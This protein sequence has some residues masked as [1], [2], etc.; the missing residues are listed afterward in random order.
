[1][2]CVLFVGHF[3][4][5]GSNV[6]ETNLIAQLKKQTDDLEIITI[7]KGYTELES[8]FLDIPVHAVKA[9]KKPV[10]DE[11]IRFFYM[12]KL[13]RKW[14]KKT[15]QN[16]A[17][18][19]LL[20]ASLEITLAVLIA[21]KLFKIKAASLIID[22]ALGNFKPDTLWNKYIYWCY[23]C[24]EKLYKYLDGSMALNARVFDYLGL[25][26]KPYHLTKIGYSSKPDYPQE[27]NQ[28][29]KKKIVYTGSLMY[30]DGTEELMEAVS[31]LENKNVE[32]TIYGSGPLRPMVESFVSKFSNIHFEG[33]LS[34]DKIGQVLRE[35]DFLVNPRISYFFTDVFG[36]PSK[37]I[38]YLLSGTPVITTP[39]AAMPDAYRDFVY[40]IEE[41]STAGIKDAILKAVQDDLE[42]KTRKAQSAYQYIINN[43]DYVC[44]VREMLEFVFSLGDPCKGENNEI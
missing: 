29:E 2:K 39:F 1:M 13:L 30:Y 18:I 27:K 20:N 43:N 24:G 40:L 19:I 32:L 15:N 25:T 44:I 36:F 21:S 35:A 7:N 42:I 6:Y 5:N 9:V 11:I 4:P 33:Y 10:V 3:L 14:K 38:E 37:M 28:N 26:K 31:T 8:S 41:E 22:T 16:D 12:M 34:N 17:R 23:S